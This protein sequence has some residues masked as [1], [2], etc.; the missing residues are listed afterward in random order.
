VSG[1]QA[2]ERAPPIRVAP[3]DAVD[4]LRREAEA[5]VCPETPESFLAIGASFDDFR[6][7]PD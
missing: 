2:T 7:G 5:L 6:R 3:A 4:D 1:A